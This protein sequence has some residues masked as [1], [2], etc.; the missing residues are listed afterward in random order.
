MK[1]KK[2]FSLLTVCFVMLF[3]L[4]Q[5]QTYTNTKQIR[6]YAIT[7]AGDTS[8]IS[9]NSGRMWYDHANDVFRVNID[10][11]NYSLNT[12][13]GGSGGGPLTINEQVASYQLVLADGTNTL[14]R[15]DVAGANNLTVPAN[16]TVAFPIGTTIT[17]EQIGAGQ[18]T[19][20]AGGGVTINGSAGNLLSPGQN[21]PMV[22]VKT[23]TNEWDLWN[24]TV[25]TSDLLTGSLTATRIPFASGANTL[26]DDADLTF[27]T[28]RITATNATV[29]TDLRVSAL[30][31]GRITFATTNSTLA[32]NA[33]LVWDNTNDIL[34]CANPGWILFQAV[35]TSDS[36]HYTVDWL[37]GSVANSGTTSQAV[38][39]FVSTAGVE[40]QDKSA[41]VEYNVLLTKSD[42]SDNQVKKILVGYRK[43]GA[44]DPVQTGSASELFSVGNA[45]PTVT[46][47]IT[48]GSPQIDINDNT[49]G[50]WNIK[51]WATVSIS[52]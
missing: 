18:T 36:Q 19:V 2:T 35:G 37:T 31:P 1:I 32:D 21:S 26:V 42:G 51:V 44:A 33:G 25:P 5:A 46:F 13:S 39:I 40:L 52:N 9:A 45:T 27:A 23:A 22:L 16:A 6:F 28:D 24:G 41:I 47:S 17:I 10:G 38:N 49:S 3:G 7:T 48:S 4:V 29:T 14:V 34:Q 30:T 8:E 12:G 11:T 43:D 50:G 15:M 20:V